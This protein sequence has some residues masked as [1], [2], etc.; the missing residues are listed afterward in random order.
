MD[1]L[2]QKGLIITLRKLAIAIPTFA[3]NFNDKEVCEVWLEHLSEMTPSALGLACQ[4]AIKTCDTFPSIAKLRKLSGASTQTD[5][6]LADQIVDTIWNHLSMGTNRCMEAQ[7]SMGTLATEVQLRI[8]SWYDLCMNTNVNQADYIKR[9]WRSTALQ[10]LREHRAG[11]P[12]PQPAL[13]ESVHQLVK[14]ALNPQ[15]KELP[16]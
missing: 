11:T 8:G 16:Q 3:P 5:D 1:I 2:E 15:R 7:D 14:L 13:P 6:E 10:V 4:E 12:N 9:R